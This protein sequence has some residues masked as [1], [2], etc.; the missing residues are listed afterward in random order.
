MTGN[1]KAMFVK[2]RNTYLGADTCTYKKS[3][4]LFNILLF[5]TIQFQI[6]PLN[7]T[8]IVST[9]SF[10]CNNFLL[11][12]GSLTLIALQCRENLSLPTQKSVGSTT[13]DAAVALLRDT[14]ERCWPVDDQSVLCWGSHIARALCVPTDRSSGLTSRSAGCDGQ[15]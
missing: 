6:L 15:F 5:L 11:G 7:Y 10:L 8:S 13:G 4:L 3:Q 12:L 14:T 2:S 1:S 9:I